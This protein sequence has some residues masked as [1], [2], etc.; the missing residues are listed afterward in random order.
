MECIGCR[1][2]ARNWPHA[3]A[4][5]HPCFGNYQPAFFM[6]PQRRAHARLL[7]TGDTEATTRRFSAFYVLPQRGSVSKPRVGVL[8]ANPGSR[9]KGFRLFAGVQTEVGLKRQKEQ[10]LGAPASSPAHIHDYQICLP[11]TLQ[12]AAGLGL[13]RKF[14]MC[15][16]TCRRGRRRSQ[17]IS[18]LGF[19]SHF[20]LHPPRSWEFN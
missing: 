8:F 4:Q 9:Y 13:I 5:A 10:R 17:G 12:V 6:K 18:P 1:A 2:S 7:P 14:P 15:A 16:P 3:P 11:K 20:R 19:E